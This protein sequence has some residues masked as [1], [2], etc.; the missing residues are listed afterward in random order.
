[1]RRRQTCPENRRQE[2]ES[3]FANQPESSR[4]SLALQEASSVVWVSAA[5]AAGWM[6]AHSS[7]RQHISP[8]TNRRGAFQPGEGSSGPVAREMGCSGGENSVTNSP[9]SRAHPSSSLVAREQLWPELLPS[10]K[11]R[12]SPNSG[13][14]ADKALHGAHSLIFH[15]LGSMP[16]DWG[17][18][19]LLSAFYPPGHLCIVSLSTA[20]RA[21]PVTAQTVGW[22]TPQTHKLEGGI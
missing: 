13:D 7:L 12:R 22:S 21:S 20:R 4:A 10:P 3:R 1:M 8:S 2:E 5:A 16:P 9:R 15:F 11:E 19:P 6:G 17:L 18:E 14:G